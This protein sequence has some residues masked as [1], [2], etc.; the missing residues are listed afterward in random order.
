M[1]GR[2]PGWFWKITWRY[3]APVLVF[4][5][6]VASLVNMGIKPIVYSAWHPELVSVASFL[7]SC[8]LVR[9]GN[10]NGTETLHYLSL[11]E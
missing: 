6:L 1:L 9:R 5:I 2:R 10:R 4:G 8:F 11:L 7:L 3:L